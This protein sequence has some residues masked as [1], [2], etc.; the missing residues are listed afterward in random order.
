MKKYLNLVLVAGLLIAGT[1]VFAQNYKFGHINTQELLSLMPEQ[2]SARQ[3]LET[4]TRELQ[5][6]LE[7]MQVELNN[8]Y[9]DYINEQENL[10]DLIKQTKEQELNDLQTRIQGFQNTA[11]QDVSRK[12]AELLNP[13]VEKA[14]NA[15]QEVAKENGFTYIFDLAMGAV[16]YFSQDSQNILPLVKKKLAIE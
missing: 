15:I 5:D 16:L 13:I 7:A 2:D 4:Y 9:N 8:K 10:T 1:N 14:R 11:Q 6:Q 12:E 3:I